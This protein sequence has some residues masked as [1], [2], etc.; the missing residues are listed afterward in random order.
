MAVG[1]AEATMSI[2]QLK[3]QTA[4]GED[5]GLLGHD[6]WRRAAVSISL[7]RTR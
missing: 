6:F 2:R 3:I 1:A 5:V 7:S 4:K